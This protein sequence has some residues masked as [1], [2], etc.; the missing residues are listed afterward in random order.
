MSFLTLVSAFVLTDLSLVAVYNNSHISKPLFYKISG[1]WGN[2]E[3]SLMLW[4]LVL[5]I[6][7]FLFFIF[8]KNNHKYSYLT[9]I[10]QNIIIFAFLGLLL[11][12]SNPFQSVVPTQKKD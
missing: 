1:T 6:F 3:G 5:V 11:I 4:V 2:H 10:I 8:N 7:S 9:L 12:N